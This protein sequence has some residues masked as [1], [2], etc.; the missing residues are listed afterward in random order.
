MVVDADCEDEELLIPLYPDT[1]ARVSYTV[2]DV[3]TLVPY[4]DIEDLVPYPDIDEVVNA[5][6]K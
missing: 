4:L 6:A 3:L 1:D 5:S 2:A